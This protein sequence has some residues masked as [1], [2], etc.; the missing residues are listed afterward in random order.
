VIPFFKR[1][2]YTIINLRSIQIRYQVWYRIR[3]IWRRCIGFNYSFSISAEGYPI[4]LNQTIS[5]FKSFG[6]S[7]F[8]FLNLT[9]AFPHHIIDWN[10]QEFG[11]LWTY[12]INYFD[13]LLQSEMT[14]LTGKRLI[15]D[16]ISELK[17]DTTA[18][19]P[20]PIAL[21]GINWI[22]FISL[23]YNGNNIDRSDFSIINSSLY[24][25]YLILFDKLEYH[26]LGNHLIEDGFSLLFGAYYFKN[27][28]LYTKASKII[29]S[30]LKEQILIDGGHF[31]LSPMYHQIIL[32]RLLDCVNL[33]QNNNRFEDQNELLLQMKEKAI[34][35]LNWINSMTFSN[36]Q[37]PYLND[38]AP[39]IAPSTDELNQYALRLAIISNE[40]LL[41]IRQNSCN[42]LSQSGYRRFNRSNYECI[43][44]IGNIG[45]S[46]QPGHAHADTFNFVL[47]IDNL[48]F[49]VDS[50]ISTYDSNQNRFFERSTSAHNTV[51]I[52]G[53]NSSDVW[54]SFRV[55]SRASV[56]INSK[57]CDFI[58]SEHNGYRYLDTVHRRSWHFSGKSIT[59]N[60]HL[61]GKKGSGKAHFYF[62]SKYSPFLSDGIVF[63]NGNKLTF[64]NAL[65]I[66]LIKTKIPNGFNAFEDAFK[67]EVNFSNTLSTIILL[68]D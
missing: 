24:A 35:M 65:N 32:D 55:A 44:D 67:L 10:Y 38:A 8:F 9:K 46:Y 7:G 5:K 57:G 29:V 50:G 47:N 26:L 48:P 51:T 27:E 68:K 66:V 64:E 23:H 31:E 30:E 34:Q 56:K 40:N 58:D 4:E 25:Q 43:I 22:K 2:F 20:Y 17:S 15:K 21:R 36:G 42:I 49:I 63:L 39:N 3:R 18:L 45:A 11:K 62:A 37:I 6:N 59:I 61:I 16:Y 53:Q 52:E 60:D 28:K 54:S 33:V 19:D 14:T 12:H 13:F 41:A 1:Y